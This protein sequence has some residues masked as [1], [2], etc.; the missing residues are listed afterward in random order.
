MSTTMVLGSISFG[1]LPA[2]LPGFIDEWRMSGTEAG[3]LNGSFFA[4][5][6]IGVPVLITITDRIDA[7]R[8]FLFS[9][10]LSFAALMGFAFFADGVWS[11]LIMRTL[12]G[13]GFAG[14]YMPGL[15]VLTDRLEREDSSRAIA[16]YTAGYGIGG[17]LSFL[18]AG[19]IDAWLDWHWAFEITEI[20]PLAAALLVYFLV[21]AKHPPTPVEPGRLF[22]FRPVFAN[23]RVVGYILAYTLHTFELMTV[24][25]WT[26]A[27]LAF[28]LGL[29]AAGSAGWDITLVG[30][31]IVLF[32]MPASIA[33]NELAR[34]FGRRRIISSLM[35][36]SA[37][38]GAVIGFSAG[39]ALHPGYCTVHRLRR[40][41]GGRFGLA[42]RRGR[43]GG[44]ARVARRD[45]GH[46]LV[47]RL[48]GRICR[49]AGLRRCA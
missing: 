20:G 32:S 23:R 12:T 13:L 28:S 5:Y 36:L 10:L 48:R 45:H 44:Q 19:R 16:F 9:S 25:S 3:W 15:K 7:R 6:T 40:I 37:G 26:V 17:A 33:G 8:V 39:P 31:L 43:D 21:A 47:Y 41:D 22:D 49:T 38:L 34:R 29:Q 18:L 14:C 11:A 30:A 24:A 4:G 46:A 42:D 1:V 35:I 27:F 2:L